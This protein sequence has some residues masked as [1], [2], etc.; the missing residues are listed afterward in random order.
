VTSARTDVRQL[1]ALLL[2]YLRMS[3]RGRS[4]GVLFRHRP[5]RWRGTL[6]L[7][8]LYSVIGSV[9]ALGASGSHDPFSFA[10]VLH[11]VTFVMLGMSLA[12]ESGELLFDPAERDLLGPRPIAA[13]TLLAA[14]SLSLLGF[15]VLLALAINVP[16]LAF[17]SRI[18]ALGALFPAVHVAAAMLLAAGAT[19]SVVFAYALVIHFVDRERFD[20]VTAWSQAGLLG[21]FL[22]LSQGV[23][24]I[25]EL[26][27][28]RLEAPFCLVFPPAWFAAV[29]VLGAGPH[30]PRAAPLALLAVSA[31]VLLG[32][33]A[34]TRLARGYGEAFAR[35]DET[36]PRRGKGRPEK[37]GNEGLARWL[38]DPVERAAFRLTAI[39]LR[40]DREMRTRLYPSLGFF[41]LLPVAQLFTGAAYRFKAAALLAVLLLG[42]LPSVALEA[43]RVSSHHAATGLFGVTP[44]RS[45]GPLFQGAR[46]AVACYLLL[47]ATVLA[48]AWVTIIAPGLLGLAVPSLVLLPLLSLLPATMRDYV[49]LS[50][51][52]TLGRQ[53]TANIVLGVAITLAGATTL[54]L[55]ALARGLGYLPHTIAAGVVV[56]AV[57]CRLLAGHIRDRPFRVAE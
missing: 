24:H 32:V 38:R 50:V 55:A 56:V 2:A 11:S 19:A 42:M 45:A 40:R 47:P 41:L 53:S 10:L 21:V 16:A 54:G 35:L 6:A 31:T 7:L 18:P 52:P 28:L 37:I 9:A 48:V 43:L 4:A 15:A 1:R 29:D 46:K 5:G 30:H 14:K 17:A 49:P 27:I 3:L 22:V 57:A 25:V 36:R 39:Y 26:P 12:A 8:L 44:L 13:P 34:V 20:T 33:V 51:P 23:A